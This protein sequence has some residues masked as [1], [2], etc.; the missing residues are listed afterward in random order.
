MRGDGKGVGA[1]G[2]TG[3]RRL[4]GARCSS[5]GGALLA[6]LLLS[7]GEEGAMASATCSCCR[8]AGTAALGNHCLVDEA[9]LVTEGRSEEHAEQPLM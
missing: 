4:A 9:Q 1:A 3:T 8:A 2:G 6:F 5:S 7:T